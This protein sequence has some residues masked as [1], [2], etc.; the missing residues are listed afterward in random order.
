MHDIFVEDFESELF[1]EAFKKY[2]REISRAERNWEML[3]RAMNADKDTT[4]AIMLLDGNTVVGFIM[5]CEIELKC[6]F[7]SEKFGFIR[8]LWV[9]KSYRHNGHGRHLMNLSEKYFTDKKVPQMAL[10]VI[11]GSEE[12]YQKQG[13]SASEVIVSESDVI[14]TK[15][16]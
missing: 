14:F 16:I 2:F 13:Y 11:P 6:I 9:D 7:F 4:K 3:F 10:N 5:F 12:F 8:E 15:K 1:T